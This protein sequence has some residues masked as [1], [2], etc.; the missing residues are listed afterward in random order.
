MDEEGAK[1]RVRSRVFGECVIS[2]VRF[3]GREDG[4]DGR[5]E[6]RCLLKGVWEMSERVVAGSR[7]QGRVFYASK[8]A[9][10][11]R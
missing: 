2:N 9:D 4:T 5:R 11:W 3:S 6:E 10:F 1:G 8:Q 7:V